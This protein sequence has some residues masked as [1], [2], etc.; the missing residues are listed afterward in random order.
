V[1]SATTASAPINLDFSP[2]G[3]LYATHPLHAFAARCPPPLADWAITRYSAPGEVV[4][5][6]MAGSG[7]TM[8]EGCLLGRQAW[9]V[10]I[11]PLAHRI[12]KAKATPGR[13]GGP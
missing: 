13:A 5:D 8:V 2:A 1:R 3:Y 4:L 10:E 12:A 11:D 7:T 9:G 6:P